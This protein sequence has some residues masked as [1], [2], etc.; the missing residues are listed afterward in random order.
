MA[1]THRKYFGTDGIRGKVG[2]DPITP[3]FML[4]LAHATG[5]ILR[6]T[7][8]KPKVLIAKDTRVSG[9]M[10]E[11]ALEA[12][13]CSAGVDVI[14]C[15][16]LPTPGVAYLTRALRLQLGVVISASHNP[17]DDNG[18]KFFCTQGN[19]LA[20]ETE[21][22]I[23]AMLAQ[24]MMC[25]Q[26]RPG[27]VK[28]LDDA[29]GRYVEFC[30]STFEHHNLHDFELYIDCAHGAAYQ[31]APMVFTELG[32]KVQAYANQPNGLNI[33]DHC[34]AV[35]PDYLQ[36]H[37]AQDMP[38]LATS[39]ANILGLSLDGDADRLQVMDEQKRLY[40]GDELLYV[41]AMYYRAKRAKINGVVGTLMTN[42][43]VEHALKMQGIHMVRAQVGDRYVLEKLKQ[44]DCILGAEGS[45]HILCLDKHSTGDAIIS[46][47]QVMSAIKTLG[48]LADILADVQMHHQKLTNITLPKK[49]DWQSLTHFKQKVDDAIHAMGQQGRILIRNSGTEP[50]LR[51]MVEASSLDVLN[52]HMDALTQ[53]CHESLDNV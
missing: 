32:A 1:H 30:K 21:L 52:H 40:T 11:S 27:K 34:G 48:P 20:D 4:R 6:Q 49:I 45:G 31:V 46:A 10:F 51:I 7:Y 43:G 41:L 5:R 25:E 23:E 38:K 35:H 13:F 18:I 15:G 19:K 17:F 50:K 3:D 33:N 44:H 39:R 8:D 36:H 37:M 29:I 26:L 16:P 12:G 9:Y 24:N 14:L 2:I 22:A 28:R 42:A 53:A 47:L